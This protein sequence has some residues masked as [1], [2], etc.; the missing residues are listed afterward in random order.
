MDK[1]WIAHNEILQAAY[2]D[3]QDACVSKKAGAEAKKHRAFE[4]IVQELQWP[5]FD[6]YIRR[7]PS[8]FSSLNYRYGLDC[9]TEQC[10]GEIDDIA[11]KRETD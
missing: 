6:D 4:R 1:E 2:R 9:V 8:S 11:E 7:K 5:P 10:I 3:Y